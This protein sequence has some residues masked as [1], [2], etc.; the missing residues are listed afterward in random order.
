MAEARFPDNSTDAQLEVLRE[1]TAS[2][3]TILGMLRT[4]LAAANAAT[5]KLPAKNERGKDVLHG[6]NKDMYAM[7]D[8]Y[9]NVIQALLR[10]DGQDRLVSS[11]GEALKTDGDW[12]R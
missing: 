1:F 8:M 5:V 11:G 3:V 4:Q 10:V 9:E 7:I 2:R 12:A 6:C